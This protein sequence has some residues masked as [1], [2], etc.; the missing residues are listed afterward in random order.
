MRSTY[1]V[2]SADWQTEVKADSYLDAALAG[3]KQ[4]YDELGELFN[5]SHTVVVVNKKN[6]QMEL[7]H[8]VAIFQD[9][10]MNWVASNLHQVL[11]HL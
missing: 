6:E 11:K 7:F 8:S 5:I 3:T 2:F 10:G 9:L 1:K 4:K